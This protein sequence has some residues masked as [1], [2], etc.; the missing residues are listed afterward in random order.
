MAKAAL[1]E[2]GVID[3]AAVRLPLIEATPDQIAQLRDGLSQS[4][5]H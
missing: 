5:L 4:G 1:R 2:L 3:S